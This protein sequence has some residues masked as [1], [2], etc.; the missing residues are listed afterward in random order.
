MKR[1]LEILRR[2]DYVIVFLLL[3]AISV[4][5]ITQQTYYQQSRIVSWGNV[6][7]GNVFKIT[8]GVTQYFGLRH[9]NKVLAE[10]NAM[11]RRHIAESYIS[12]DNAVFQCNDTIYKQNYSYI[13]ASVIKSSWD[14]PANY[15]MINKGSRHGVAPD[16]AVISPQGIVGVVANVS[17]NFATVMT[18]LHPDSRNSVKV[19][20]TGINGTLSWEGGNYRYATVNDIPTTHRLSKGDTIITSGQDPA[21]PKGIMAG[22]VEEAKPIPGSGFYTISMR[23]STEF[24]H[25][26]NVYVIHNKFAI[27][28]DSLMAA[29][30]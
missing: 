6:L 28:Q 18:V 10:E 14:N 2:N 22:F 19:M 8:S 13:T 4:L 3:I 26:Q 12:Y 16:M 27:E 7:A 25:L 30:Q 5:M 21:F 9:E 1:L 17:K 20:R 29:T 24:N 11:L 15:I 23:L